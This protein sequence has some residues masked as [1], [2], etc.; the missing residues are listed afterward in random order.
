MIRAFL[1]VLDT[2]K[3]KCAKAQGSRQTVSSE[4]TPREFHP[5]WRSARAALIACGGLDTA[6]TV[7]GREYHYALCGLWRNRGLPD[8]W[9]QYRFA[10]HLSSLFACRQVLA[11]CSARLCSSQS[12]RGS[13]W[14]M[15]IRLSRNNPVYATQ[16]KTGWRISSSHPVA[17]GKLWISPHN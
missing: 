11:Y 15:T 17:N 6:R 5:N 8:I 16:R 7:T 13:I 4:L 2:P 1:F 10:H 14:R 3:C 12:Q 9:S